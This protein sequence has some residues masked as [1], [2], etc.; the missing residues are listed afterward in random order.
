MKKVKKPTIIAV[1]ILVLT[2]AILGWHLY[3]ARPL[4]TISADDIEEI[5]V[6]AFPQG[7]E[8]VL[9]EAEVEQAVSLLQN[10]IVS[11][12]GY[13]IFLFGMGGQTVV[14]TVQKSGGSTIE[15]SNFGNILITIN[16]IS[17]QADYESAEALN[18][19]A[20]KALETGF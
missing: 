3:S 2:V 7:K 16:N 19:F 14:F 8:I 12:P 11:K 20:N 18:K 6:F 10:L 5:T 9:S 17:Y 4:E 15:I 13:G 1:L